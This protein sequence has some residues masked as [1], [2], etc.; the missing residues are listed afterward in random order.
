M[1]SIH[2]RS[3]LLAVGVGLLA[4]GCGS[5]SPSNSTSGGSGSGPSFHSLTADAY[6]QSAC[7]RSHGVS[8]FPDPHIITGKGQQIISLKLPAGAAQSPAFKAAQKACRGIMPAPPPNSSQGGDRTQAH[9][10]AI[11]TFAHCLRSH[12]I[13]DFPDPTAQGQLTLAMVH[14]AGVDLHSPQLLAAAKVCVPLTHGAITGAD[15]Q[16]AINSSP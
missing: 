16:R 12:G 6:K 14:A 9:K 10:Q 8:D 11:L 5:G 7:M 1:R 3:T 4:A 13:S 15:V 2:A